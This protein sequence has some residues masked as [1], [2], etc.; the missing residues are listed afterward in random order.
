MRLRLE[1][2]SKAGTPAGHEKG[3]GVAYSHGSGVGTVGT[4]G[5]CMQRR[6]RRKTAAQHGW[7]RPLARGKVFWFFFFFWNSK[8]APAHARNNGLRIYLIILTIAPQSFN[9]AQS[10][11]YF[12]IISNILI[13]LY[14]VPIGIKLYLL[15]YISEKSNP[16]FQIISRFG[17]KITNNLGQ[18]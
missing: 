2:G 15:A 11:L 5:R 14:F 13:R 12:G 10:N 8:K 9:I 7:R 17:I 3:V 18:N 16:L 4:S 1:R 6:Q